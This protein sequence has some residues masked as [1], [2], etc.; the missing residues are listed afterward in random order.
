MELTYQA[1][2]QRRKPRLG[3][4]ALRRE[5]SADGRDFRVFIGRYGAF[6]LLQ[7]ENS[8]LELIARVIAITY[9]T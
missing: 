7:L 3:F 6:H 2:K 9:N 8:H 5:E 1:H 4:S